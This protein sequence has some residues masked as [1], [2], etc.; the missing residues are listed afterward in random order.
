M[1]YET[2]AAFVE[3]VKE[4]SFVG[5]VTVDNDQVYAYDGEDEVCDFEDAGPEGALIGVLAAMGVSA[6]RP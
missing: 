5:T 4:G 1:K 3:A 6:E 2:I